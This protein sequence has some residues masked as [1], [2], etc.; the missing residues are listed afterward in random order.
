MNGPTD[1]LANPVFTPKADPEDIRM[2]IDMTNANKAIK[3][4]RHVIP[5]LEELRHDFNGA[6]VFSVLDQ[7]CGYNQYSLA[8]GESRN[9]TSFRTH[10]GIKRF[11]RLHFGINAA[12]EIF[13]QENEKT[14]GDIENVRV[15]YDDFI[16]FGKTREEHNLAL[17]RV[18]QRAEDC[19]LTFGRKKC[20]LNKNE[21]SYFGVTFNEKGVFPDKTKVNDLKA[22]EK[23]KNGK[24]ALSFVCMA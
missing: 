6:K 7:N 4:Q 19:G 16:I 21:V 12:A 2:N 14:F 10:R 20:Q 22:A 3:R 1:W 8:P 17:A 11:K 18:L 9:I 23:P 24:E 13:Q 5:T 15:I